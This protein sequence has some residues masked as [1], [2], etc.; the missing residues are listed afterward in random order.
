VTPQTFWHYLVKHWDMQ[1]M[2]RQAGT[3]RITGWPGPQLASRLLDLGFDL[4]AMEPESQLSALDVVDAGAAGTAPCPLRE[5]IRR[6]K[7]E[8]LAQVAGLDLLDAPAPRAA[9][10]L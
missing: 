3:E 1:S 8:R 4:Q 6:W 10:K 2:A 5:D 7:R 9:S